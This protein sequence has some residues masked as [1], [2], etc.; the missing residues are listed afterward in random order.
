MDFYLFENL[1]LGT[2]SKKYVKH[3]VNELK[4][5]DKN[6]KVV[7]YFP[8]G[9]FSFE[10]SATRQDF[11]DR[12]KSAP[13]VFLRHINPIDG[14]VYFDDALNS[15][16]TVVECLPIIVSHPL[17]GRNVAVQARRAP[18]DYEESLY[19]Y[20]S[21][22]DP[23][24]T[25]ELGAKPVVKKPDMIISLYIAD[26]TKIKPESG[27][28][29]NGNTAKMQEQAWNGV[30]LVG[31]ST[32]SH[33]ICEWSGGAVRFAKGDDQASR[34]E[35]K[36]LEAMT[37]FGIECREG[38]KAL[39]LGSSPGGWTKVL[40]EKGFYVTSVDKAPLNPDVMKMKGVNFVKKD[41]QF[42]RCDKD[43]YDLLTCDINRDPIQTARTLVNMAPCLKKGSPLILTI[44]FPGD[45]PIKTIEKT[46]ST[47]E[48]SYEVK[49]IR[50]LFHNRDEVTLYAVRK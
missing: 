42:F 34:A 31:V 40:A 39:D 32:P 47:I 48:S 38:Q 26:S 22:I 2:A 37:L 24:L 5:I 21:L 25:K 50:Q 35:F 6:L 7:D 16:K 20:K 4:N 27:I 45:D 19:T 33:N 41:A 36:L 43:V 18:G 9:I 3:A 12:L 11:L 15:A 46:R 10:T 1:Y 23:F 17:G 28:P 30:A 49:I 13:P 14:M 29:G 44:K 8:D